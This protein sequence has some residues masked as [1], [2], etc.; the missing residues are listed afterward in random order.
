MPVISELGEEN[1]LMYKILKAVVKHVN[2]LIKEIRIIIKKDAEE[3]AD[4]EIINANRF[5]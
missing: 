2:S 3:E 1:M 5:L 4:P